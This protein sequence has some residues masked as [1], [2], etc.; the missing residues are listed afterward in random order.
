MLD[1]PPIFFEIHRELPRQGPGRDEY[2]RKAFEMLPHL[3]KPR[4]LD[5]GCGPG[6]QTL[7]LAR[8]SR[9]EVLALDMHQPYLDVLSGKIKEAGFS[10][11]VKTVKGSMFD[12]NLKEASFDLIWAEGSIYIM[13][14]EQGLR[15]WGRFLNPQGFIGVTEVAWLR[16]NPPQEIQDFWEEGYPGITTI[17]ENLNT[18][19]KCG[20]HLISHFVLPEDAWWAEY[21]TPLEKRIHKLMEK[22]QGDTESLAVLKG[23]LREIDLYRRYSS[24]YGYVFFLMQK[25]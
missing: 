11:Q 15:N 9:G 22:Y 10:D 5:I 20:Y 13:G 4:I 24:W 17:E 16:A 21:Y 18:V 8:L 12:L 3:E 2:T 6:Q 25:K 14:F 7:E 1:L 19:G 23:E